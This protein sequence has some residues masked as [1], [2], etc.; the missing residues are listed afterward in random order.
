[1]SFLQRVSM[2]V[3]VVSLL[4]IPLLDEPGQIFCGCLANVALAFTSILMRGQ[5]CTENME[6]Q[7]QPIDRYAARQIP[8]W[9]GFLIGTMLAFILGFNL[10]DHTMVLNYAIVGLAGLALVSFVIYNGNDSKTS[11]LLDSLLTD[12]EVVKPNNPTVKLPSQ[13]Y[14]RCDAM[15]SRYDLSPR[16]GEIFYLLAKGRNAKHIQEKLC[17]SPSTVKTHIYRIYR[18]MGINS[19]QL[20]IDIVDDSVPDNNA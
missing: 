17:I 12:Q 7:L 11:E 4:L 16:E 15:I 2:P 3:V 19:Q 10:P 1:N 6:F 8:R 20:L 5:T 13:F 14:G 9:T 18:K